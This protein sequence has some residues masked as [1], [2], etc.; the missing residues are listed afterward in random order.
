[1]KLAEWYRWINAETW[2]W[3]SVH[4]ILS[5]LLEIVHPGYGIVAYGSHE[6]T[7]AMA[8]GSWAPK[9]SLDFLAAVVGAGLVMLG[10]AFIA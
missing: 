5:A 2:R 3:R 4:L 7:Q 8:V 9:N 1:M 10:R 6:I